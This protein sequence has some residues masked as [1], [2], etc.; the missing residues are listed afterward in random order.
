[1]IS[2][3]PFYET[4]FKNDK[5]EYYLIHIGGIS[6]NTLHRMKKGESITTKT[7]DKLCEILECKVEDIIQYN[8]QEE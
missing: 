5:T 1:M 7:I 3:K 2:Y 6:A 8:Q 4:L